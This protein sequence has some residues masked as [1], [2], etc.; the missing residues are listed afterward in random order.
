M[1]NAPVVQR[2]HPATAAGAATRSRRPA[3]AQSGPGTGRCER[4]RRARQS[5]RSSRV[6]ASVLRAF[7]E[8]FAQHL[9]SG[10]CPRPGRRP[11]PKLLDLADGVAVYDERF[12]NKRADW[13]YG[14]E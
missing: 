8:E 2:C 1:R 4:A 9:E 13:T 5:R 3:K 12:W 7:P 10:S 6:V 14:D 11:I